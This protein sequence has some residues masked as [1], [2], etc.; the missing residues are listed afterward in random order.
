MINIEHSVYGLKAVNPTW[1]LQDEV[2]SDMGPGTADSYEFA[3]A[4]LNTTHPDLLSQSGG[5]LKAVIMLP[6]YPSQRNIRFSPASIQTPPWPRGA[7]T[8]PPTL[9]VNRL[10][11]WRMLPGG[12]CA[13]GGNTTG[14]RIALERRADRPLRR[15]RTRRLP[16][17]VQGPLRG[18]DL[19]RYRR[20]NQP[21]YAG[22]PTQTRGADGAPSSHQPGERM[23][24]NCRPED[25]EEHRNG[26]N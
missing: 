6:E 16:D 1:R 20:A 3:S 19:S 13:L 23:M 26:S 25:V 11:Q 7:V 4:I 22:A 10:T 14:T 21:Q 18:R 15:R 17:T 24:T 5:C 12:P 2:T 8:S 9:P